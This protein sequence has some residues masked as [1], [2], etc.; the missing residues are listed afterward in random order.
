VVQHVPADMSGLRVEENT[1]GVEKVEDGRVHLRQQSRDPKTGS[2]TIKRSDETIEKV[3]GLHPKDGRG[4]LK[5]IR[6]VRVITDNFGVA[7]LDHA[8]EGEENFS[9]VPWHKVWHRL[10]ELEKRNGGKPPRLLRNGMLI[11]VPRGGFAGIWRV[12]SAKNNASGMA[13]DIGWPDVIRLRNKTPGHKI[14][15]RLAT[16]LRD[17]LEIL[18]PGLAGMPAPETPATAIR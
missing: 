7:L 3:V 9:I 8:P 10:H 13:L 1:R 17:G 14:N 4:K 15:V 6:G 2:I 16:L 18:R 11:R 12:F 5:P